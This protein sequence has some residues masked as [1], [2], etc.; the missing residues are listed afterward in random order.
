V[1]V[2]GGNHFAL[3]EVDAYLLSKLEKQLELGKVPN[4]P[5]AYVCLHQ[6]QLEPDLNSTNS[7]PRS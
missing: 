3:S 7:D 4:P 1:E 6:D 5:F 2:L